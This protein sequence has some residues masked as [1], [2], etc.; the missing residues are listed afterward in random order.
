[1]SIEELKKMKS[2]LLLEKARKIEDI[3]NKYKK[4]MLPTN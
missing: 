4:L 3:R 2:A 1:M